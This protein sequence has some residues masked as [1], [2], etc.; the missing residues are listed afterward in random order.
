M[1]TPAAAVSGE[2]ILS[3]YQTA[4][5]IAA[6][7]PGVTVGG[8]LLDLSVVQTSARSSS[9]DGFMLGIL[10]S[11]ETTVSELPSPVGDPH[12]DWMW[13]QYFAAPGAA[14]GAQYSTASVQSGPIRIRARRR[15]D[16]LGMHLYIVTA[17][18]G[19]TTYDLRLETSTLLILP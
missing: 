16:E 15:M 1:N 3:D 12:A 8:V 10:V 17:L 19:L 5:G 18:R 2:D 14:S 7:P 4:A 11:T 13:Y 6:A 9:T